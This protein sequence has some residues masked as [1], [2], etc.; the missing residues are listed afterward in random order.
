MALSDHHKAAIYF[1]QQN[2][3]RN[4]AEH[5]GIDSFGIFPQQFRSMITRHIAGVQIAYGPCG[6]MFI[7]NLYDPNEPIDPTHYFCS[8]VATAERIRT[9]E[10]SQDLR[11]LDFS[12]N[13]LYNSTPYQFDRPSP[14]IALDKLCYC[15]RSAQ[16]GDSALAAL[17]LAE[18][19]DKHSIETLNFVAQTGTWDKLGKVPNQLVLA[20]PDNAD[21]AKRTTGLEPFVSLMMP[22]NFVTLSYKHDEYHAPIYHIPYVP[23]AINDNNGPYMRTRYSLVVSPIKGDTT[24][25]RN[26]IKENSAHDVWKVKI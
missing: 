14:I 3:T 12:R 8:D 6:L 24:Y 17:K 4:F 20:H 10:I 19:I 7:K 9:V 5:D 13:P 11:A 16:L 23:Y 25:W 2:M 21:K 1:S 22:R 26:P 18:T 15:V